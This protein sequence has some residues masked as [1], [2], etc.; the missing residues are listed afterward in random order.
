MNEPPLLQ[1]PC[2]YPIKVVSRVGPDVRSAL[3]AVFIR[4]AGAAALNGVTERPSG[5]GNFVSV[6]YTI[7][8]RSE[9]HIAGLF[10]ELKECPGVMMVL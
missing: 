2:E 7:E 10:A 8:A 4:H 1:F 9:T 5:K 6:T 3:D